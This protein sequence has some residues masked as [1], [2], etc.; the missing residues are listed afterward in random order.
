MHTMGVINRHHGTPVGGEG[1]E[2]RWQH[3][4]GIEALVMAGQGLSGDKAIVQP[5]IDQAAVDL[6][7]SPG[8]LFVGVTRCIISR[9]ERRAH[10][11]PVKAII[12]LPGGCHPPLPAP[13]VTGVQHA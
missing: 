3:A 6:V 9:D 2:F 10:G 4:G 12:G 8:N 5:L 7:I 1:D 13:Q 11:P